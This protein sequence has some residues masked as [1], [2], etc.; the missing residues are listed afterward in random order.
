VVEE[1]AVVEKLSV[2]KEEVRVRKDMVEDEEVV[3]EDVRKEEVDIDDAT[4]T[5]SMDSTAKRGAASGNN[6]S[7]S[8]EIPGRKPV[9]GSHSSKV[10]RSGLIPGE[11]NG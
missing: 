10:L 2:V 8:G 1:E 9:R 4:T 6:H 3:E 11:E 5:R 7:R